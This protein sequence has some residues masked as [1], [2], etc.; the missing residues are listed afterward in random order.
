MIWVS[1]HLFSLTASAP[2]TPI[3][4]SGNNFKYRGPQL[5]FFYLFLLLIFMIIK[6]IEYD[7]LISQK[8]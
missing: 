5:V 2:Q 8:Q 4:S 1:L 6:V 7:E 3:T